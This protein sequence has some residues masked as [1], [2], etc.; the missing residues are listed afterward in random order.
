M[1]VSGE[2]LEVPPPF[3]KTFRVVEE[4]V[5][6]GFPPTTRQM[7]RIRTLVQEALDAG[8]PCL[9]HCRGGVGRT[10]TVIAALLMDLKG[11]TRMEAL[12][13]VRSAGRWTQSVDQWVFLEH[14]E[15]RG[16]KAPVAAKPQGRKAPTGAGR[17]RR[18][19]RTRP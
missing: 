4:P 19:S 11:M 6:D 15:A 2:P 3:R 5:D 1:N 16:K 14:W 13:E 17:P 12:Q 18:R 7:E 10:A 8:E 9:V